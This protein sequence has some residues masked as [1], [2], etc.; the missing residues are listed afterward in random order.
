MHRFRSPLAPA[1]LSLVLVACGG[2]GASEGAPSTAPSAAATSEEPSAAS[3]DSASAAPSE[4][5][6]E[7]MRVRLDGFVFDPAELT[8]PVGTEVSFLNADSAPHTVTEGVDGEAAEGP[9]IDD[10]VAPNQATRYT[11]DEPG[12][13]QI[14]CLLHPTMNLTVTVEG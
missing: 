8:I 3:S 2:G 7:T 10:E 14:T 9:F 6:S 4:A 13:F 11:F 5:G 12:T 1:I